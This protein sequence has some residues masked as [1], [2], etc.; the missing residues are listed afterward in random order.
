MAKN[1][2]TQLQG[3]A[4]SVRSVGLGTEDRA[5]VAKPC[6]TLSVQQVGINSSDLRGRVSPKAH[7]STRDLIDQFK[8]LKIKRFASAREQ[9]LNVLKQRG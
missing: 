1:F 6:D 7:H 2:G 3:L 9:R 4:G 8:S 5:T